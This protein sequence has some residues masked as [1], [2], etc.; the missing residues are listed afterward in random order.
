MNTYDAFL[1]WAV[2]EIPVDDMG[3][4]RGAC[5]AA[6]FIFRRNPGQVQNDVRERR[7]RLLSG[8]H[9]S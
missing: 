5:Q 3:A 6:A 1:N 8:V 2:K 9:A 7:A 4:L